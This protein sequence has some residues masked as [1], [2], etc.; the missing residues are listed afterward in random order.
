VT[1]KISR[2]IQVVNAAVAA[3]RLA[4]IVDDRVYE[5]RGLTIGEDALPCIDVAPESADTEELTI[6]ANAL[7]H[8]LTLRVDVCVREVDGESVARTADPLMLAAHTALMN[9]PALGALVASLRL[10]SREWVDERANG[11]FLRLRMTY[12]AEHYSSRVDLS[13][14][15]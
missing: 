3:L 12:V 14:E 2:D 8:L 10:T 6:H 4:W 15:P 7:E 11:L 1:I 9:D 5:M 13:L